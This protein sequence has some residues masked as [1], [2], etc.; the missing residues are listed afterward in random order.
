MNFLSICTVSVRLVVRENRNT[1]VKSIIIFRVQ[2]LHEF[3]GPLYLAFSAAIVHKF[4]SYV[5]N[6]V[7]AAPHQNTISPTLSKL[8]HSPPL[9]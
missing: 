5:E 9:L 4:Y 7:V 1:Y 8:E 2:K 3:P 6:M